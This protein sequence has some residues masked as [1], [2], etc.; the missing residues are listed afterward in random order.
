[1]DENY[2]NAIVRLGELHIEIGNKMKSDAT[3]DSKISQAKYDELMNN[4]KN[5]YKKSISYLERSIT[6]T[7][8]GEIKK[9][10]Y[11][12]LKSL[13]YQIGDYTKSQ[14][15]ADKANAL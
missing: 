3:A 10:I 11:L 13:Y 5:E 6:L 4:T 1:M 8:S 14:E 12:E 15:M 2:F 7:E 9:L